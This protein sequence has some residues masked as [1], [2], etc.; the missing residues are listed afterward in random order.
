MKTVRKPGEELRV[1]E[2]CWEMKLALG[3]SPLSFLG[4]ASELQDGLITLGGEKIFYSL[5]I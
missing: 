2:K 5:H 4:Q 1:V 3:L